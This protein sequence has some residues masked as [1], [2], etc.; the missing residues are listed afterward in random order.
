MGTFRFTND[1]HRFVCMFVLLFLTPL[2]L[3]SVREGASSVPQSRPVLNQTHPSFLF[4]TDQSDTGDVNKEV[5]EAT[6]KKEIKEKVFYLVV[7]V[8]YILDFY[9]RGTQLYCCI[10][11]RKDTKRFFSGTGSISLVNWN[12]QT[13]TMA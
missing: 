13:S 1:I 5:G 8:R 3:G 9:K 12:P 11:W 7:L 6:E 2:S 4:R 10:E